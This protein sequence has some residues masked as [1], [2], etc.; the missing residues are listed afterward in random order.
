MKLSKSPHLVSMLWQ[1]RLPM[2]LT[3][4]GNMCKHHK[5]N[6]T[7]RF[8]AA[9]T[10]APLFSLSMLGFGLPFTSLWQI[11]VGKTRNTT[12]GHP[13]FLSPSAAGEKSA[14]QVRFSSCVLRAS[15]RSCWK[16]LSQPD[17]WHY[18][19]ICDNQSTDQPSSECLSFQRLRVRD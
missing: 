4:S 10:P 18:C 6:K 9:P 12:Q 7:E 15:S 19:R 2:W 11:R 17:L 16:L 8:R 3:S 1:L 13:V 14:A 5:Q